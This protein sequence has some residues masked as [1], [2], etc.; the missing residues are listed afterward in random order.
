MNQLFDLAIVDAFALAPS[1]VK[2]FV[3]G[4]ITTDLQENNLNLMQ[5][6]FNDAEKVVDDFTQLQTDIESMNI[7]NI[8]GDVGTILQDGPTM[9]TSCK[10]MGPDIAR[11]KSWATIFSHPDTIVKNVTEHALKFKEDLNKLEDDVSKSDFL[12]AGSEGAQILTLAT[13]KVPASG[14]FTPMKHHR[15]S[16]AARHAFWRSFVQTILEDDNLPEIEETIKDTMTTAHDA[17]QLETDIK[18]GKVKNVIDIAQ[19]MIPIF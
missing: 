15:I 11:V 9:F 8:M 7:K 18:A 6:C 19:R 3:K 16:R 5:A 10:S 14:E 4:F 17:R 1:G 2:D 12:D 13:G